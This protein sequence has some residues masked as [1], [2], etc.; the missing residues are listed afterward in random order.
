MNIFRHVTFS[1]PFITPP[2]PP[3]SNFPESKLLGKK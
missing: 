2:P 3:G 1:F